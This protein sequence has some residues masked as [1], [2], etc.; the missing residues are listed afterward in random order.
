M[1]YRDKAIAARA[2]LARSGAPV[3]V[4]WTETPD[5]V[6]G[7]P[8]PAPVAHTFTAP[9][10]VIAFGYKEI[11]TQPD[12]LIKAGDRNLLLAACDANGDPLPEPP[13][14]AA[15]TLVDGS[16]YAVTSCKPLAPAG[17]P[18]M[19]DISIRR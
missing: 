14:G 15:V 11:G 9:G 10:A 16:L 19:Y 18:V 12:S 13:F 1:T 4:A 17:V 3:V 6:P 5:Y 8:E 2:S 7:E